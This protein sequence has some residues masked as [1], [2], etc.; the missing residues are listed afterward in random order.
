MPLEGLPHK[1]VGDYIEAQQINRLPPR[2]P[3]W[4]EG[5]TEP[6]LRAAITRRELYQ[7]KKNLQDVRKAGVKAR[8]VLQVQ[9][10]REIDTDRQYQYFLKNLCFGVVRFFVVARKRF[11]LSYSSSKENRY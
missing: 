1:D 10:V 3:R 7:A 8:A 11:Q 5:R 6:A 9:I 2:F 4:D